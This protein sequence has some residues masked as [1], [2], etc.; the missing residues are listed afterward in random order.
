MLTA[1]EKGVKGGLW[2]SLIDKVFPTIDSWIRTRL[3]SILR[4]RHGGR[5][6]GRG[7]DHQRWPRAYFKEMGL[8][9]LVQ[10]HR[11]ACESL[12]GVQQP[13]SRMR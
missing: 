11:L 13:E 12:K 2:F 7:R 5:G 10:A 6:R 3:R 8:Y 1:L 9:S 4:K